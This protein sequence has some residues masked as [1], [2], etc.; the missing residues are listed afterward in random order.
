MTGVATGEHPYRIFLLGCFIIPASRHDLWN[1]LVAVRA[2]I[3]DVR[4]VAMGSIFAGTSRT[5]SYG[6]TINRPTVLGIAKLLF[7]ALYQVCQASAAPLS[8][9]VG[10]TRP[11]GDLPRDAEDPSLWLYLTVAAILVL[12]GGAFAGLTIA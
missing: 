2:V 4:F 9:L 3:G 5:A 12:L 11:D 8:E 10:F 6:R 1:Q 7:L